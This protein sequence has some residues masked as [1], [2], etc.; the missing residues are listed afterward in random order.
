MGK[1]FKNILTQDDGLQGKSKKMKKKSGKKQK[2]AKVVST[3]QVF[4]L[5]KRKMKDMPLRERLRE[6]LKASR[7][8]FELSHSTS[9]MT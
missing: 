6:Q 1:R 3:M 4:R 7:F 9:L 8:R 2:S 5:N